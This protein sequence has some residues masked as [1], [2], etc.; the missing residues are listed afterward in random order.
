[1]SSPRP[2]LG[3][4]VLALTLV[5][6]FTDVSSEMIYPLLPIFLT[7]VLGASASFVG[8]MEGAAET[9]SSL[10]KLVSGWWS[11]RVQRRKPLVV[12]GYALASTMR[13]LVAFA[14][15]ASEVL[16][17][18][19][20]DR[21]GKGI[22]NAPR[23]ALIA[24]SVDP[25]IWGRAFGV[26]RAGD[27]AGGVVGPLVAFALLSWWAVP[28]RQVFLL[29]AVPGAVAV[30]VVI[31][32][33]REPPRYRVEGGGWRVE[34]A[35]QSLPS[36]LRPLPSTFWSTLA[37]ILLF[38]LGNSTDAFL[39]L[40]ATQLGV[41]ATL[42]PVLWA[43]LHVVKASASAPGGALSDR[44]GRKPTLIAGWLLY[45]AV[46]AGFAVASDAWHAWALFA[47]Y[48]VFFGLTEGTERA[49]VAD[50]VPP[51]RRGSAFGWYHLAVGLGMF[52]ASLLFGIIWDRAGAPTAFLVGATLS[53]AA[54]VGLRVAVPSVPGR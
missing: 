6:F 53:V 31:F 32:G 35:A 30:L 50:I 42:A 13:P 2:T 26:H 24:D 27:H 3:R 20:S 29:A 44:V 25:A 10:L 47:V 28:M 52:P 34:R 36:T 39:L 21:A 17:I 14:R 45:A 4:N 15:S 49:L 43:V 7:G 46:Y 5:S 23:D 51:D 33:V 38:T 9:T 40:R 1:M 12:F 16:V 11:D 48:G 18:R 19:L 54:A 37:V 41:P 8:A 22:R